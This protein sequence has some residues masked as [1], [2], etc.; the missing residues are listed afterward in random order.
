MQKFILIMETK[1]ENIRYDLNFRTMEA[2]VIRKIEAQ[3][4]WYSGDVII[5]E[6]V[7]FE[8]KELKVT[9]IGDEAFSDC[10][11]LTSVTIPNSVTSIGESAF[12]CCFGLT[13][14]TIPDSVKSIGWGA[15]AGCIYLTSVTIGKGVTS[16]GERAFEYCRRLSSINIPDSVRSIGNKVFYDCPACTI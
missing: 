14:V 11:S 15:F 4:D 13:S 6:I 3:K 12:S 8:G 9:S 7:K 2:E 10:K 16:I 1:I 5:P